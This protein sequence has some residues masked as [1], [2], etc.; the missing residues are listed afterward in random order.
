MPKYLWQVM[1]SPEGACGVIDEGGTARCDAIKHMVE[2]VGGTVE[3]C[4][5]SLGGQDLYVIGDV[6]DEIAAASLSIHTSASGIARSEAIA[7][8]TPEQMDKATGVV[9]EE[10]ELTTA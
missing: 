4:Y 5:F 9:A 6:P 1:Y 2:R 10:R 3:A 8:V 7:L